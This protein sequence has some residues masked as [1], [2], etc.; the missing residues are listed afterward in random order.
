MRV[1]RL[2][3]G[4]S[5]RTARIELKIRNDMKNLVLATLAVVSLCSCTASRENEQLKSDVY[6]L[7]QEMEQDGTLERYDGSDHVCRLIDAT[8]PKVDGRIVN[9]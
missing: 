8:Y 4:S 2:T 5:P 6:L 7:L 9:E 1:Q 3:R